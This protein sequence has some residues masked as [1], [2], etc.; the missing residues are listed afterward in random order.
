MGQNI[1]NY[2]KRATS[3]LLAQDMKIFYPSATWW[4]VFNF[5]FSYLLLGE[6]FFY[7]DLLLQNFFGKTSS[8]PDSISL[9]YDIM[10]RY[11]PHLESRGVLPEEI[12]QKCKYLI[13]MFHNSTSYKPFT[14]VLLKYFQKLLTTS[15]AIF[16]LFVISCDSFALEQAIKHRNK[17]IR[18]CVIDHY[19]RHL[20][21]RVGA[22]LNVASI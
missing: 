18:P 22:V 15:E 19:D 6:T 17:K 14:Q 10:C 13:E 20:F 16:K 3:A 4:K 11:R 21:P 7:P 1:Q 2:I 9:Y 8:N 12:L 5:D